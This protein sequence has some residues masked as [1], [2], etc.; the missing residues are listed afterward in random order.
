MRNLFFLLIPVVFLTTCTQNP[1]TGRI[2]KTSEKM[3]RKQVIAIAENYLINQLKEAK[4]T[5]EANGII[6]IGNKEKSYI[7]DPAGVHTG[8]IDD[9]SSEDAIVSIDSYQDQYLVPVYHLILINTNGKFRLFRVIE[10]DMKIMGIKNRV[11][12]ADIPTRPPSSPLYHCSEC[13]DTVNYQFTGGHLIRM[14]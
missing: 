10:S 4:K 5:V 7:I 6:T 1:G 9:D 13:R 12:T 11:I 2:D 8:I 14:K 3:I